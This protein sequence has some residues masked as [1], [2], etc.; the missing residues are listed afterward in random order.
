MRPRRTRSNNNSV[1]KSS[2]QPSNKKTKI[3]HRKNSSSSSSSANE[4]HNGDVNVKGHNT[5]S[6]ATVTATMIANNSSTDISTR[7]VC[8]SSGTPFRKLVQCSKCEK[9]RVLHPG[10]SPNELPEKFSCADNSWSLEYTSCEVPQERLHENEEDIGNDA[11]NVASTLAAMS[12]ASSGIDERLWNVPMS[13]NNKTIIPKKIHWRKK[14]Y[15][16]RKSNFYTRKYDQS[17]YVNAHYTR[18]PKHIIPIAWG[19]K[20]KSFEEVCVYDEDADNYQVQFIGINDDKEY[21][22]PKTYLV[23][24]ERGNICPICNL[25]NETIYTYKI[26]LNSHIF[27]FDNKYI[28]LQRMKN[29][30]IRSG[31]KPFEKTIPESY[32]RNH[33]IKQT[34]T[35]RRR[36]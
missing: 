33:F 11:N 26:H 6:S 12:T 2:T 16:R 15:R 9:W 30:S 14:K 21:V 22:I 35:F 28:K 13:S 24:R 17:T 8:R 36:K 25:M 20:I 19:D 34:N 29:I 18:N 3:S 5:V 4:S 1:D 32:L 31:N 23:W 27:D 10:I 7:N